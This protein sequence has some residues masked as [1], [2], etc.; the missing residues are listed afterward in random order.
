MLSESIKEKLTA[1]I[2]I[3][4]QSAR[5]Y[6]AMAS[7]CRYKGY[8]G[9]A[10]FLFAH[11]HEEV[12]HML[13]L[14]NYVNETGAHAEIRPVSDV[15]N[16]F[17]SLQEVFEIVYDHEK[18]ITTEINNLVSACWE[19]K[20]YSTFNFLQWYVGEQHEEEALFSGILDKFRLIGAGENGLYLVDREIEKISAKQAAADIA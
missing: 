15:V 8:E 16:S 20:D 6:L 17:T 18:K 3:E 13:K 2:N 9:A 10:N 19:E 1:Q 7:W 5:M 14:L 12:G 11:Y 4:D